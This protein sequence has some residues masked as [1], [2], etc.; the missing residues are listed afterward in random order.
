MRIGITQ[1]RTLKEKFLEFLL[2]LSWIRILLVSMRMRVQSLA[3]F[4]GVKD[5]ALLQAAV[6]VTDV[7]HI[8]RCCGCAVG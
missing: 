7:A 4:S 1:E 8:W 3:S 6:S 5:Q 2:W